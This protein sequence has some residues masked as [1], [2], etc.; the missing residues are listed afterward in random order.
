MSDLGAYLRDF[1]DRAR[2]QNDERRL[3]LCQ[4]MGGEA[5]ALR[6]TDPA[7]ALAL[8]DEGSRLAAAL[9]EPIWVFVFD[10]RRLTAQMHFLRDYRYALDLAVKSV[11][12]IRKS[13]F[14]GLD[15]LR[16]DF[17]FHL[18]DA[19]IGI[20]PHGHAR[21]IR[22]ALAHLDAEVSAEDESRYQ[23]LASWW[24]FAL[25]TD[26]LEATERHALAA[27]ARG[28]SDPNKRKLIHWGTFAYDSLCCVS[29]RRGDWK[30][31]GE[32]GAAGEE[33]ARKVGHKLELSG[34]LLWQALAALHAGDAA[35]AR[36][37]YRQSVVGVSR[38]RM[39]PEPKYFD[40]MCAFLEAEGNVE[41]QLTVRERELATL[42]DKGRFDAESRCRLK[43]CR[44]LAR[45]GRPIEAELAAA[46]EVTNRLRGPRPR[47]AELDAI[48]RGEAEPRP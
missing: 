35:A 39:P 20:D 21:E 10:E 7:R 40:A 37:L 27:V 42:T 34:L 17:H 13:T 46:R 4:L 44:L 15:D 6:E 16:H 45:L 9:G 47:L 12:E 36:R 14:D 25:A 5:F 11:L 31:L 24:D 28:E 26:D 30:N 2:E 33:L 38:L 29:F 23:L 1:Y 48:A 32:R 43:R 3:R 19:Y 41:G 22:E 8:Y 18:I